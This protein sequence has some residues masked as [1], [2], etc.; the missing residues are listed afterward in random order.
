M[1]VGRDLWCSSTPTPHSMQGKLQNW[2]RVHRAS[3][4][5]IWKFARMKFAGF[6][7]L[8]GQF[9]LGL[10]HHN[11]SL[12]EYPMLTVC[13]HCLFLIPRTYL[14]IRSC[15]ILS[16]LDSRIEQEEDFSALD[17]TISVPSASPCIL[18]SPTPTHPPGLLLDP[19]Q[20][21]H[22]VILSV[23]SSP[24]LDMKF[25]VGSLHCWADG[26]KHIPHALSYAFA[27]QTCK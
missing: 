16:C 3:L 11:I 13:S 21:I 10:S 22:L 2:F 24:N 7:N 20:P 15:S 4:N 12:L 17:W 14:K 6:I 8:S 5:H 18:C 27:T 19:F 1:F 25:Q 9:L 23:W 26:N